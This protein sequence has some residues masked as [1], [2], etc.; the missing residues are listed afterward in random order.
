VDCLAYLGVRAAGK[1]GA[2]V[3]ARSAAHVA[4][5][6]AGWSGLAAAI[7]LLDAGLRVTLIDAAPQVGGRARRVELPLGDR[8]Y[9]LDNGQHLLIGAYREYLA[10]ARRVG[11]VVDE[12]FLIRPFALRYPDGFRIVAARA[13]A[14]LHLAVALAAAHGLTLRE[15]YEAARWVQHW[16]RRRWTIAE[17]REAASLFSGHPA[18]LVERLWGPLCL[19]AL[20]VRLGE[21]SGRVY[22]RVLGDTLGAASAA[23]HLLLPR[24]DASTLFPDAAERAI[25]AKGGRVLLRE[26]ALGLES[27]TAQA[28]WQVRLRSSSVEADAVILA[29]PPARCTDL[30]ERIARP[31]LQPAIE[32][33][34]RIGTAPIATV[35]L[36][37]PASTRLVQP[38]FAL[39]EQPSVGAYGQWVFDRGLLEPACA[40]VLSVVV[41]GAGP[42]ADLSSADL[43][44]AVAHQLAGCFAL[45]PAIAHSVVVEKRATIVPGPGLTRPDTRLPLPGLYTAGDAASSPYPSTLEG[46]ICSGL[47]AARAAIADAGSSAL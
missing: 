5:I 8:T 25:A 6:G 4:I 41:S 20:N 10:L 12:H 32:Q 42:H 19:A 27:C 3:N 14:P 31:E 40:G 2:R 11:L 16:Q 24:G 1:I 33:L 15:R 13:P 21:A 47:D 22:L 37:Y 43:A 44:A 34:A 45:P 38:L 26:A 35:Y 18:V 36:R 28:R 7:T 30:L 39:H 23:S 9:A 46:S 29:L 17:D